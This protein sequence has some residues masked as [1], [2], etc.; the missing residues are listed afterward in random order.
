MGLE[1]SLDGPEGLRLRRRTAEKALED[2]VQEGD[3]WTHQNVCPLPAWAR[4]RLCETP[5]WASSARSA[6]SGPITNFHRLGA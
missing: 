2:H 1:R 6:S 5:G 4:R 3:L